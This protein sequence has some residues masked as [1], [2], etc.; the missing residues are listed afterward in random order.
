MKW[1][2]PKSYLCPHSSKSEIVVNVR[3]QN[4]VSYSVLESRLDM[5]VLIFCSARNTK[6]STE[7]SAKAREF[8]IFKTIYEF[9]IKFEKSKII[10]N[11]VFIKD[12]LKLNSN[13]SNG[14][15]FIIITFSTLFTKVAE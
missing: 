4:W 7:N 13:R 2:S 8:Q 3:F 9:Q 6:L 14:S 15:N 1:N 12:F 10:I 5:F 11:S